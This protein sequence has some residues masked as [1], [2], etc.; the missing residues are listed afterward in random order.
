MSLKFW[1]NTDLDLPYL[2]VT[3]DSTLDSVLI[4]TSEVKYQRSIIF[5]SA[6]MVINQIEYYGDI[7]LNG[8]MEGKLYCVYAH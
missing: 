8:V 1:I 6:F 4:S 2:Q 7:I 5:S 3:S